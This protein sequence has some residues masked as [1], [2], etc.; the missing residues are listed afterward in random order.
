MRK[1][2]YE[3]L[4]KRKELA[5]RFFQRQ[6]NIRRESD[7]IIKFERLIRKKSKKE[8]FTKPE[9]DRILQDWDI[10]PVQD[11]LQTYKQLDTR[12]TL[13]N[14]IRNLNNVNYT[15]KLL[16]EESE[17][18]YPKNYGTYAK[19]KP[20]QEKTKEALNQVANIREKVVQTIT[21]KTQEAIQRVQSNPDY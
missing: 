9:I 14:Y 4:T 15:E 17:L 6:K 21:N 3:D 1:R 13:S 10:R 8:R 2:Y 5:Y 20:L 11:S 12:R 16:E 19:A 7:Q 18:V